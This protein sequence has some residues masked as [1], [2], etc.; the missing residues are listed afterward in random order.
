MSDTTTTPLTD[1]HRVATLHRLGLLDTPAHPA[2]DRL[3][4]LASTILNTPVSLVSLIDSDRE[5]CPGA[6][7][8]P[9][10]WS[11]TRE[12]PLD[13]SL[14]QHVVETGEA[15]IVEDT[16]GHPIVGSN[17][18]VRDFGVTAYAGMPLKTSDGQVL[19]SFCVIDMKIRR[20]TAEDIALLS[21]LAASVMTEIEL[22]GEVIARGRTAAVLQESE[23]RYR[24]IAE[25]A[26]DMISQH[27]ADG[28]FLYAS[29]A[30]HA[31]IGYEP[32]ELLGAS[33]QTLVHPDDVETLQHGN[34]T[35][36]AFPAPFTM[37]FRFLTKDGSYKWLETTSQLV[38]DSNTGEVVVVEAVSHDV[39]ARKQME[40][41]L[42][43][44]LESE[45]ELNTLKARF[46][47]MVSHEFRN[48]LANILSSSE[49]LKFYGDNL[50][51][52]KKQRHIDKIQNQV[53]KLIELLDDVLTLSK[54][55]TIS[56][57][58]N[59]APVDVGFLCGH[60]AEE[61]QLRAIHTHDIVFDC[62]DS[63]V[64][65]YADSK[66]LEQS[67]I[68]LL[69]NAIK[70]SPK[71]SRVTCTVA[72]EAD[73]AVIRVQDQGIG[74]T[75]DDLEHLFEPFYRGENVGRIPGT[76]LGLPIVKQCVE[77]HGGTVTCES[78]VGVGTT[79]SIRLP[80]YT[81]SAT[82]GDAELPKLWYAPPREQTYLNV[83]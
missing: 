35:M 57:A 60:L 53:Q 63:P 17:L 6:V 83:K 15:L 66:L 5:V 50:P 58:F 31:L 48:P 68:N 7:G 28:V 79:F 73:Q 24:L 82:R 69:S 10:P 23:T 75:Q 32:H 36:H 46:I 33:L 65:I 16:H 49:L 41:E 67:V 80:L 29:P 56:L 8:L 61:M 4:R 13:Y 44:A 14:C 19:G 77:A 70:Y 40:R 74:I 37:E 34:I 20:W 38:R 54:A 71:G 25:N 47:S 81:T 1:P 30:S 26:T 11:T 39:S 2:F 18:A 72:R 43:Q 3:T 78:R 59:P 55:Q 9:E 21:D 45:Q 51:E 64:Q 62:L 22:R 52:E 27:T 12:L 76:G 42:I